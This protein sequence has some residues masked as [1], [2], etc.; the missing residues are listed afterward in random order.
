MTDLVTIL[1]TKT[2]IDPGT[3]RKGLGALLQFVKGHLGPEAFSKVQAT[4]PGAEEMTAAYE[5]EKGSGGGLFG[6]LAGLAGNLMGGQAGEGAKLMG[7]LSQAGL[8]PQQVQAFL[9]SV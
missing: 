9:P 4:L 6:A 7:M 5:S 1:A 8:D 2:G 3:I